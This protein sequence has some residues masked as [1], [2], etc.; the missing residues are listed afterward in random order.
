MTLSLCSE[1]R[2][3]AN[4]KSPAFYL[5]DVLR[6]WRLYHNLCL[7]SVKKLSKHSPANSAWQPFCAGLN[8]FMHPCARSYGSHLDEHQFASFYSRRRPYVSIG[9]ANSLLCLF[10]CLYASLYATL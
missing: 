9:V 3:T 1:F 4:A 2:Y 5:P 8:N 6:L 10:P 7:N